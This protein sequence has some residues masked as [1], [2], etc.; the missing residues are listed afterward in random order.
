M[1]RLRMEAKSYRKN[2]DSTNSYHVN[3]C[4]Q[5]DKNEKK[6]QNRADQSPKEKVIKL[7][8]KLNP[9][10]L[11]N[12]DIKQYRIYNQRDSTLRNFRKHKRIGF[13][14][15]HQKIKY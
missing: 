9:N 1:I 8:D 5:V 15:C 3:A 12:Q 2:G 6:S 4:L 11:R 7:R 13:A 10:A 14:Q